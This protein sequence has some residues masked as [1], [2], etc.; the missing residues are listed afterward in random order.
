[1]RVPSGEN[2]T[3]KTESVCSLNGP[4]TVSPVCASHTRMVRSSEPET[5]RALSGVNATDKT[6]FLFPIPKSQ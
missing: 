4:A 1:M 2:A 6:G 5:M 3:D